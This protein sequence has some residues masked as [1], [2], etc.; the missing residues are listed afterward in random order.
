MKVYKFLIMFIL[1]SFTISLYAGILISSVDEM[2]SMKV[3][4]VVKVE[5]DRV[6]ISTTGDKMAHT[7]I[8]RSD[9]KLFW[10]INEKNKTYQQIT[11]EDIKKIK[12]KID[13]AQKMMEEQ[14][15]NIP[16][17]QRE[18]M[19]NMMSN[20]AMM[21]QAAPK[22]EL[23]KKATGQKINQWTCTHFEGFADGEKIKD[24]W[25][26]DSK[27]LGLNQSDFPAMKEMEEFFKSLSDQDSPFFS[28]GYKDLEDQFG[29]T[30]I[31]VKVVGL[32]GGKVESTMKVTEIK[33][34]DFDPS[35]FE[36]PSGYQKQEFMPE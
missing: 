15:K 2:K 35:I 34:Q 5:K 6:H 17:A 19:K 36:L 16:E 31:P 29:L 13:E 11:K 24:I 27:T 25:V 21:Q 20:Q 26:A 10:I 4:S 7:I 14:M 12:A 22:I 9:K 32:S 18:M 23:K 3:N 30:G 28:V 1:C 8:F 33:K